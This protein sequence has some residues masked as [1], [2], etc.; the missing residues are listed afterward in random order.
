M[1]HVVKT[2]L[3]GSVLALTSTAAIAACGIERG[4]IRVLS[5][6]FAAMKVMADQLQACAGDKVTV[7]INQTV[8]HKDIQVAALTTNPAQYSLAVVSNSSISPLLTAD[9]IRPLD[10]LVAKYGA[11]LRPSQLIKVDGKTVAI[12]AMANAQHFYYRADLLKQAGITPPTTYEEVIAAGQAL[13]QAGMATPFYRQFQ[14]R[15]ESGRGICQSLYGI[16][17]AIV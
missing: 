11:A 6:D 1:K 4:N 8:E 16:W 13:K 3:A 15:L 14:D 17:R 10:D 2:L 7:E 5:N 12:A 9:L